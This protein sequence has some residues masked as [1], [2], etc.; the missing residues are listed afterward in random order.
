MKL[1]LITC[2]CKR[3]ETADAQEFDVPAPRLLGTEFAAAGPTTET[4]MTVDVC[5]CLVSR[6]Q[7]QIIM[8]GCTVCVKSAVEQCEPGMN[9]VYGT[10]LNIA[11][12]D[13]PISKHNYF[14]V[15]SSH[16]VL[17]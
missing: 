16:N 9:Y 13:V 15:T 8:A 1:P 10:K 11:K 2:E 7:G 12:Q 17:R 14:D 3:N 5:P 6:D 4:S